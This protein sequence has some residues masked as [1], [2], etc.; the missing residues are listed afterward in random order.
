[1]LAAPVPG[2]LAGPTR[3]AVVGLFAAVLPLLPTLVSPESAP[4]EAGAA[5]APVEPEPAPA[6]PTQFAGGAINLLAVNPGVFSVAFAPEGKSVAAGYGGA[7]WIGGVEVF[8]VSTRRLRWRVP[9]P[10]G[11]ASVAYTADG[12]AL[13]WAGW[14]GLARLR[15]LRTLRD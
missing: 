13:A 4:A 12:T 11:V 7:R 3:L 15:D 14:P 2:R 9:E 1:I 5:P 10:R 8:D 6:E